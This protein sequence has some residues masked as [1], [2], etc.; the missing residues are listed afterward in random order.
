MVNIHDF[1]QT[2]HKRTV[3]HFHTEWALSEYTLASH[4]K[5]SRNKIE[6]GSPLEL[7][8]AHIHHEPRSNGQAEKIKKNHKRD[9]RKEYVFV[10]PPETYDRRQK[11]AEPG[12]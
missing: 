1:L 4:K 6:D 9:Y 7:L 5:Y 8:I 2:R 12:L 11:R 3:R 10:P